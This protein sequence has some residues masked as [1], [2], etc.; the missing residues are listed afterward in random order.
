MY[1]SKYGKHHYVYLYR[2]Q[3]MKFGY[4]RVSTHEQN[5]DRQ[6]DQLT[7]EGCDRIY[8]EK[9]SG[10]KKAVQ[11]LIACLMPYEKEIP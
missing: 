4:A 10:T 11:N 9:A 6:L 2:T 8:Q 5:L 3:I 1:L 7:L